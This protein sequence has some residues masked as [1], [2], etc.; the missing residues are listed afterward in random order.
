MADQ[1]RLAE[2]VRE[3]DQRGV[4]FIASNACMPVVQ[5]LYS[6]FRQIE[7][8]AKRAINANGKKRQPISELLITNAGAA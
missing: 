8:K 2:L 4:A 7:V 6:G 5:E 1:I 3:L